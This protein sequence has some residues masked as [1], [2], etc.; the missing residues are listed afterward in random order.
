MDFISRIKKVALIFCVKW[1]AQLGKTVLSAQN[2]GCS[3]QQGYVEE[4]EGHFFSDGRFPDTP[5]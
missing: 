5:H 3:F 2:G 1:L 4:V